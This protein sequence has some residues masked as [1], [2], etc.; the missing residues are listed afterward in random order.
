MSRCSSRRLGGVPESS[1]S[2]RGR[3]CFASIRGPKWRQNVSQ[4]AA[5]KA[6]GA[7]WPPERLLELS[8]RPLG[9][10]WEASWA[11]LGR[12]WRPLGRPWACLGRS[13]GGLGGILRAKRLSKRSPGG[14]KIGSQRRLES[15]TAKPQ[16][17]E[18][19]SRN[20]L[21]FKA[22]GA[23]FG[24]QNGF[25]NGVQNGSSMLKALEI[26]L[27]RSWELLEGK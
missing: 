20:S 27:E 5:R 3:L 26:L 14:F 13:W 19:V 23:H 7:S 12:S 8:C 17:F 10:V 22:P 16:N 1:Q 11:L 24:Y 25:Q 15:K 18:D 4:R 9:E 6:L 2:T 21:V